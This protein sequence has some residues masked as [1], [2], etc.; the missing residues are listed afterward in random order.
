M[1]LDRLDQARFPTGPSA[2]FTARVLAAASREPRPKRPSPL[3]E[4][5]DWVGWAAAVW[6][7]GI[8]LRQFL[9]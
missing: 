1:N 3:P 9:P 8:Y 4:L 7:G 2:G 6:M 5:L